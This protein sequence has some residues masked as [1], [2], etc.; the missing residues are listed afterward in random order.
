MDCETLLDFRD[1]KKW[2]YRYKLNQDNIV[3]VQF[4]WNSRFP[5]G[6]TDREV[7]KNK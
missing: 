3:F 6:T 5:E 1:I 4:D 7:W 2:G